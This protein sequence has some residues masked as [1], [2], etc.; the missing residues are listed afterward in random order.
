MGR[1]ASADHQSSA[2]SSSEEWPDPPVDDARW[3]T[4]QRVI[5]SRHFARSPLL[6]KFLLHIVA[7]TIEGR[8]SEITEHQIGVRVFDRPSSYRTVEDNIVRNYARQLRRRL[9]DYYANEGASESLH[10]DIPLGGYIP[11]FLPA[12]GICPDGEIEPLPV[13]AAVQLESA[14]PFPAVSP[15]AQSNTG[16][17]NKRRWWRL[18]GIAVL[19][20]AY[21][22]A[23]V[24][25]SWFA[26]IRFHARQPLPEATAPLW[27]ALFGGPATSYIVPA[28]VG[29]NL[30]EDITHQS[31]PL[32]DY[33]KESYLGQPLP[34]LDPHSTE[35]L[36]GQFTSFVD[37]QIVSALE[38]LPAFN[39]QR[40]ILRFPRDL[41]LDDLKHANAVILGSKD[42]NPWAAIAESDANFRIAARQGMQGAVVI[43]ARPQPGEAATYV[44]HWN[45]PA[46]ESYAIISY[47][48]NLSGTGHLLL[49]Q[50]L[51]V[52]GT[53]AAAETLFHPAAIA[54]ILQQA[55]RPDGSLRHFEIL[56]RTTSIESNSMGTQVIATRIY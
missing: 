2:P 45:E 12:P 44:S 21:S 54:Q 51:D 36:H 46:H 24:G 19:F 43:N 38:R 28:D 25:L 32:A 39:P 34:S 56:L 15:S 33:L 6:S 41:H 35:D 53:Q 1:P 9:T 16:S 18:A 7:E 52:A 27:A 17:S 30:L 47:L 23:L 8:T 40:S 20:A 29:F 22:C 50:G 49:L 4:A 48:P 11:V 13:S 5:A 3:C 10:I 42:S 37:L 31:V 14:V 55:T 26:A